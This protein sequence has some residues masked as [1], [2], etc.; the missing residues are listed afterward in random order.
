MTVLSTT[1]DAANLT[2][3]VVAEFEAEPARLWELW[4]DPRQL[5]RWWGPPGFPA[6]FTRHE[7]VVGGQSRYYMSGPG[8]ERPH[9]WW[10]IEAIDEP[11]R[12]EFA[13]G[14]AGE[15]GEPE[16]GVEPMAGYVTFDSTN[17]GTTMTIVTQFVDADQMATLLGMG[18]PEGMALAVGQIDDLLSSAP[19]A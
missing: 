15:D 9:G 11:N 19:V 3:T 1:K 12:L 4:E 17:P 2:L 10:R 16:P 13:N 18:M 7:F 8:G 5:E 6:V 14:L